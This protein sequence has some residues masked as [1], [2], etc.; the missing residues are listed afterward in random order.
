MIKNL[1][2]TLN[3]GTKK[4]PEN[5]FS[6]SPKLMKSIEQE[7][8]QK[9][10][11][12]LLTKQNLKDMAGIAGVA[13]AG[14]AAID[15]WLE[16]DKKGSILTLASGAVPLLLTMGMPEV[17]LGIGAISIISAIILKRKKA[18]ASIGGVQCNR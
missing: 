14:L 16:N 7:T 11:S 15:K 18:Q 6:V 4:I 8:I 13:G 1:Q 17:A 2:S 5:N 10:G 9:T 3:Q 12:K